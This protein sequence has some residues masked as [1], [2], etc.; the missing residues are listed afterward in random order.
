[1]IFVVV[2]NALGKG[3][4]PVTISA[5]RWFDA[6]KWALIKYP[7]H[8]DVKTSSAPPSHVADF[9]IRWTGRPPNQRM[10]VRARNGKWEAA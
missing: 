1:M 6:R 7:D 8:T 3:G 10:E 9:E 4:L 2:R 5:E